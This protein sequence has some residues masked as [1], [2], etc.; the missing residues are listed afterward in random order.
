M[1]INCASSDP[2][3]SPNT[4]TPLDPV[5]TIYERYNSTT[6]CMEEWIYIKNGEGSTA[7]AQG[8][9]VAAKTGTVLRT[10]VIAPTSCAPIRVIGVAQYAITAGY[11]GWIMRKG[12]GEVLVDTG[13]VTADTG[14][15]VGDAVAGRADNASGVT[16]ATIG[17]TTETITAT[18]LATC[19][20]DCRG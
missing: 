5:G 2:K 17:Y 14:I 9:I 10:G 16:V 6:Q 4:S 8:T 1:S 12:F 3:A 19:W 13:G 15:I 20:I 11:Y 18:N 7:F